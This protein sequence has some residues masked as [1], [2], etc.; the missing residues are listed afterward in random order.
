MP[1]RQDEWQGRLKSIDRE[2]AASRLAI[3]RLLADTANDPTIII[4]RVEVREVRTASDELEATY[5]VRLF[6]EF[7]TALRAYWRSVRPTR[8]PRQAQSLVNGA[9]TKAKVPYEL[10]S[11]A[12]RVREYRNLV[13]HEE[14]NPVAPIRM[15]E[16]R[17]S[18]C[19][20]LARLPHEW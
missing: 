10:L 11:G 1:L 19:K 18:L 13:V 5:I 7:E 12:H 16:A 8:P 6:S 4:N 2:H 9:A 15:M 17:R 20:F 3:N 14:A